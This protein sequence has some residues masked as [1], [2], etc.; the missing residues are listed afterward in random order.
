MEK[1]LKLTVNGEPYE[2][3]IRPRITLLELLGGHF[4]L[5]GAKPACVSESC[6]FLT[7][8]LGGM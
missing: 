7:G 1:E 5:K 4:G 6:G 2:L 8:I 3:L